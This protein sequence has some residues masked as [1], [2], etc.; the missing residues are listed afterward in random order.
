MDVIRP[1]AAKDHAVVDDIYDDLSTE[2]PRLCL[3]RPVL[4]PPD[5]SG[6]A[7]SPTVVLCLERTM[8]PSEE[9]TPVNRAIGCAVLS[10]WDR[11]SA[12]AHTAEVSVVVRRP[13]RR[14]GIGTCLLNA[15]LAQGSLVGIRTCLCLAPTEAHVWLERHGFVSVGYF[16]R[17]DSDVVLSICQR[18]I[19]S[20]EALQ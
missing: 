14:R 12:Y 4:S 18:F 13:Y 2:D 19:R 3:L 20:E 5:R 11:R 7:W 10:A 1:N 9:A 8:T 6:H 16:P 15:I 17:V